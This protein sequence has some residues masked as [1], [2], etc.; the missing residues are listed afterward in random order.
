MRSPIEHQ[1]YADWSAEILH[2]ALRI[3][4]RTISNS[5][6]F[7][8]LSSINTF[9]HEVSGPMST[10]NPKGPAY[11]NQTCQG[12]QQQSRIGNIYTKCT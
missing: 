4:R 6:F 12:L 9:S 7:D 5:S 1:M 10:L 11:Q 8:A 2:A 3:T